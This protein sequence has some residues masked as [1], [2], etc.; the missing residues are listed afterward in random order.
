M[1]RRQLIRSAAGALFLPPA[2]TLARQD[3]GSDA[4]PAPTPQHHGRPRPIVLGD[5][6]ELIDYRIYPSPDVPRIIGEIVST[7][8]EMVDSPVISMT[9]PDLETGGYAWAPSHLPVM[10]PGESNLIFGVLPEQIDTEE[11]LA[12]ADFGLCASVAAGEQTARRR[13]IDLQIIVNTENYW[14]DSLNVLGTI[15]NAG[16]RAV[17]FSAVHGLVR[18]KN[19]RYIGVTVEAQTGDLA[20][21]SVQ[22]FFLWAWTA[23]SSPADPYLFLNGSTDYS[24]DV[25]AGLIKPILL[26]GCPAVF[27]WN[28]SGS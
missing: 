11:K 18:D 1:H 12:T 26:P 21:G 3:G 24:V 13:G 10:R 2:V 15:Q 14:A 5:G 19:S 23:N 9:F 20:P 7:R 16:D 17:I 8:D 28:Q 27:P 25:T 22:D 4:T 6:I